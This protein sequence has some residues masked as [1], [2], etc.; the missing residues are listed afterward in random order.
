VLVPPS[1][2]EPFA[3]LP[4]LRVDANGRGI[5]RYA[6]Y[7]GDLNNG[8]AAISGLVGRDGFD[9]STP[10]IAD[11]APDAAYCAGLVPGQSS[12]PPGL[13]LFR[14]LDLGDNY[15]A[16]VT[17][18]VCCNGVFWSLSWYEPRANMSYTL[19]LSRSI[20]LRYGTSGADGDVN[21]ARAIAALAAQLVRLT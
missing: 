19:D 16:F 5:A 1:A 2:L 15:P 11:C 13:E 18:R 12:G 3:A 17:H 8:G 9:N 4:I 21:A 14:G 6:V 7:Y 20:A 10:R